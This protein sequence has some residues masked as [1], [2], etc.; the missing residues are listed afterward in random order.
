MPENTQ[1]VFSKGILHGLP[2]FPN[3][4]GKKYSAIVTGAT[5]ISGSAIVDALLS[6]PERWHTIYAMSRRPM[7][8]VDARV[9]GVPAD[10]LN[11]SPQE[12]A[13]TF[14]SESVQA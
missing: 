14:H 4:E 5:G 1:T 7:S 10:F 9:K 3:H 6:A 8:D 2:T 13:A 11:N 12:L